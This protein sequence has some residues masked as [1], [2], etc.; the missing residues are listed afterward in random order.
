MGGTVLNTARSSILECFLKSLL[1]GFFDPLLRVFEHCGLG[2][3]PT[4]EIGT[5]LVTRHAAAV[6]FVFDGD[7]VAAALATIQTEVNLACYLTHV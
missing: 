7:F 3:A 1:H 6:I 2:F 5:A 4:A